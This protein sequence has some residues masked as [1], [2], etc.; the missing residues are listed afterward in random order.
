M[1]SKANEPT[2]TSI[3]PSTAKLMQFRAGKGSGMLTLEE[4][5]LL[6]KS[7]KEISEVCRNHMKLLDSVP[8]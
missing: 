6:R 1:N 8:K 4:I 5:G 7:K 2:V 3:T